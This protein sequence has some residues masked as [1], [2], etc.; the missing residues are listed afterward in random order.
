MLVTK[1]P[2]SGFHQTFPTNERF[3]GFVSLSSE[4]GVASYDLFSRESGIIAASWN[5]TT[6]H[7]PFT[8]HLRFEYK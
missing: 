1:K 5:L 4:Y 7:A 6:D 2:K 8:D 3:C